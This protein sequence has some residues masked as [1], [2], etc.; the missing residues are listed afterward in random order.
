MKLNGKAD[1]V[2]ELA[3]H[4]DTPESDGRDMTLE[5]MHLLTLIEMTA[6]QARENMCRANHLQ[7]LASTQGPKLVLA[8]VGAMDAINNGEAPPMKQ[9]GVDYA[10][11]A[12][13]AAKLAH[14]SMIE[15]AKMGNRLGGILT[16]GEST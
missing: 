1:D 4:Q 6:G 14:A 7:S 12:E 8:G 13:K 2:A 11:A 15:C 5:L 9:E 3:K 16:Q 10:K